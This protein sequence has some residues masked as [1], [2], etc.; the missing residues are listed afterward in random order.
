MV[1]I[2]SCDDLYPAQIVQF[3]ATG[4]SLFDCHARA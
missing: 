1:A 4:E 3:Q 2:S